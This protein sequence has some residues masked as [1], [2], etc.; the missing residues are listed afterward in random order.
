MEDILKAITW[1][2]LTFVFAVIFI[3]VFRQPLSNLIKRI[4][5]IDKEGLTAD[6]SPE[7]QR[8]DIKTST[9]AV[10]QLLDAVGNSIVID[11]QE[12]LITSELTA[13]G[14]PSESDTAKVLIKHLAGAQVL[15][16]FEQIH[17]SIFGS[18]IFLLKKLNEVAGQ[19]RT[20]EYIHKHI[21][22]VK[23]T[24]PES[25]G[26]WSYE[27]YLNYLFAQSLITVDGEQFH[28]TNIGVEYLTWVT[29]NGRREDNSL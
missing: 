29:R 8:E 6:P 12:D 5:K 7:T 24:Y 11:E 19:G 25:L 4:T 28:I 27:K 10:Q 21:D 18:Q 13:K 3:F 14:L 20:T 23:E 22:H 9:E 17:G 15:L 26:D 2:H 1:H 16:A